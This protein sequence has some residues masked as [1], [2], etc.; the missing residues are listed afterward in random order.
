DATGRD[1]AADDVAR[2]YR[3]ALGH[4]DLTHAAALAKS[5][6]RRDGEGSTAVEVARCLA[7]LDE[8]E[9]GLG[10]LEKARI[11]GYADVDALDADPALTAIRALP[12]W[13]SVRDEFAR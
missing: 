10:W 8:A 4:G 6:Y 9:E 5:L 7:R 3:A 2:V 1:F 11:A 13:P 12:A